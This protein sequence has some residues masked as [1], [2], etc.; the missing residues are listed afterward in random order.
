MKKR[1]DPAD[2]GRMYHWHALP[3]TWETM[4]YKAF[5]ETRRDLMAQV[6][7]E[8]FEALSKEGTDVTLPPF[9][10]DLQKDCGQWRVRNGRIPNLHCEL[11]YIPVTRIRAW[12]R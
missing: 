4:D 7:R 1:V 10:I 2:L 8:G 9:E 3:N 6:I 11:I 5:L 12:R